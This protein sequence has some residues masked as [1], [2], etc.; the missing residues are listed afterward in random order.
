MT[1]KHSVDRFEPSWRL[2]DPANPPMTQKKWEPGTIRPDVVLAS[3]VLNEPP[4]SKRADVLRAIGRDSRMY[5]IITQLQPII[6]TVETR[7][8]AEFPTVD[9][10]CLIV[11]YKKSPGSHHIRQLAMAMVTSLHHF[12]T[13]GLRGLKWP[14]FGLLVEATLATLHVGW[15]NSGGSCQVGVILVYDFVA[16][17]TTD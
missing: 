17:I 6:N 13:M 8:L 7:C 1:F 16:N 9:L 15:M 12:C 10:S 14:I 5:Q 11:E 2:V 3:Q 4:P